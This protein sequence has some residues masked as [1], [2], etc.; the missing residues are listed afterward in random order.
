MEEGG[1]HYFN[2]S[3]LRINMVMEMIP[4]TVNETLGY[5]DCGNTLEKKWN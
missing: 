5:L 1:K 3:D 4:M 2:N